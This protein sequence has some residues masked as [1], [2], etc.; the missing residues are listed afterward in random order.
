MNKTRRIPGRI[1]YLFLKNTTG[2]HNKKIRIQIGYA[3][4]IRPLDPLARNPLGFCGG[5]KKK[6]EDQGQ[7]KWFGGFHGLRFI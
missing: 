7:V 4:T 6:E 3:P 5:N 2:T 1:A